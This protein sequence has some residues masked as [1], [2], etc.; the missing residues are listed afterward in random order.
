LSAQDTTS[1]DAK[2]ED[3]DLGKAS[4]TYISPLQMRLTFH[5][6][7]NAPL[8]SYGVRVSKIGGDTLF[9]KK[10]LF[11]LVSAN[12]VKGVQVSPPIYPGGQ[13]TLKVLG[14]DFSQDFLSSFHVAT[15][16]PGIT[17]GPM[18]SGSPYVLQAD[19]AVSTSVAP[20]DYWLH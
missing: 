10:D 1:L 9:E 20:G 11:Q 12:W 16:D 15:D 13:G 4:F 19:I 3:F 14:R 2:T 5:S 8:G 18:R 17:I 6:P 7:T